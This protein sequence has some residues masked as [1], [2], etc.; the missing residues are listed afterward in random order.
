MKYRVIERPDGRFMVQQ[1]PF[2]HVWFPDMW[3]DDADTF[4]TEDG[5]NDAM[6][7]AAKGP[8]VVAQVETNKS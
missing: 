4:P 2:G 1:S 8:R 5:A 3:D 7:S 6:V